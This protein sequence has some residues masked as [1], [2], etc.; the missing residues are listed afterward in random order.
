MRCVELNY[1]RQIIERYSTVDVY[2]KTTRSRITATVYNRHV[3]IL[4][5]GAV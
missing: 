1:N 5:S 4:V 3:Q 2:Y